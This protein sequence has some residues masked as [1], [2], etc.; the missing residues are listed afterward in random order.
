MALVARRRCFLSRLVRGKTTYLS[1]ITYAACA[2]LT[3]PGPALAAWPGELFQAL[4]TG[5]PLSTADLVMVTGRRGPAIRA[6]LAWLQERL[7]VTV[8]GPERRLNPNWDAYLWCTRR[9]W[10]QAG[11]PMPRPLAA[12]QARRVLTA[13]LEPYLTPGELRRL[14][15]RLAGANPSPP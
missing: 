1:L 9:Q 8:V 2:G 13:T 12:G 6:G 7:L 15:A 14:L 3:P 5:G 10:E 4:E 11:S